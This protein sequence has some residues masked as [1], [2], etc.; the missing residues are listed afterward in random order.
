[1]SEAFVIKKAKNTVPWTNVISDLNPSD[2]SSFW[3]WARMGG[4]VAKSTPLP[5]KCRM[6]AAMMKLGSVISYL[7][8]IQRMCESH[9]PLLKF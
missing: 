6:Y 3:G 7:K 2:L 5:K 1:M 4:W 9:N 8:E